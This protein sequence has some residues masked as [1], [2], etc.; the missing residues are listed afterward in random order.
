[1]ERDGAEGVCRRKRWGH[2]RKRGLGKGHWPSSTRQK[3]PALLLLSLANESYIAIHLAQLWFRRFVQWH[4]LSSTLTEQSRHCW[5][6]IVPLRGTPLPANPSPT[7]SPPPHTQG[8]PKF[9]RVYIWFIPHKE[10]RQIS[11]SLSR[12]FSVF[13]ETSKIFG[14]EALKGNVFNPELLIGQ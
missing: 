10:E 8:F 2:K 3:A 1:M 6:A 11:L 4:I 14:K 13:P 12:N 9:F 7:A 5:C